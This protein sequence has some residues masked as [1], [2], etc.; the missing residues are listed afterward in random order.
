MEIASPIDRDIPGMS[1]IEAQPKDVAIDT[2]VL[3]M[4]IKENVNLIPIHTLSKVS[5]LFVL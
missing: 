3:W 1:V 2:P 5:V 4:D